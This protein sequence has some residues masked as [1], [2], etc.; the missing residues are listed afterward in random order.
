MQKSIQGASSFLLKSPNAHYIKQY[1]IG[2]NITVKYYLLFKI[3]NM[4]ENI[5]I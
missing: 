3:Y 2:L 1:V 4:N 5:F